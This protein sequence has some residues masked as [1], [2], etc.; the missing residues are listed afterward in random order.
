MYNAEIYRQA[1]DLVVLV[2]AVFLLGRIYEKYVIA[3]KENQNR[4]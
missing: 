3:R 4:S 2:T 1:K